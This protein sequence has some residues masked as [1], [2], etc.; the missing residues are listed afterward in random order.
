MVNRQHN[1]HQYNSRFKVDC[2]EQLINRTCFMYKQHKA[3]DHKD[4][5]Y[6]KVNPKKN[7]C[8]YDLLQISLQLRLKPEARAAAAT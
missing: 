2:S 3:S 7:S 1:C 4:R 6:T 8:I 5:L